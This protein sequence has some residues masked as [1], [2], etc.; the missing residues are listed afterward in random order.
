MTTI[1]NTLN[2]Q[3]FADT[4]YL[5]GIEPGTADGYTGNSLS[6]ENKTHYD[7][8]LIRA[9]QPNLIHAQFAQKRPIP[10]NS[11][12]N[13]EFRKFNPLTKATT[14]ITEGITP[15]GN[16]LEIT[17]VPAEVDQYGD[18]VTVT[19]MLDLTAIDPVIVEATQVIGN[20]AGMTLDTIVR[21]KMHACGN[22]WFAA[23]GGATGGAVELPK[24]VDE[25]DSISY[26]H[27]LTV[28]LL[29]E[30]AAFLKKNNA[31]KIDGSYIGIVH[32]MAAVDIMKDDAWI[33]VN[34]YSDA[35]KIFEGELGKIAGIRFVESSEAKVEVNAKG[36]K[37]FSTLILGQ[38]AY[39][40]TEIEGGG[41][42]VIVK[43]VGSGNDPLNQRATIGWKATKA[44][45]ILLDSNIVK[46]YS[47]TKFGQKAEVN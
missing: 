7:K 29:K 45:E 15:K 9:A 34:S 6:A 38:N 23:E 11:G 8:T 22:V 40:D 13:V 37:Y 39:G 16:K 26:D 19:D 33:D 3:L 20:Q 30:V 32:P 28:G 24:E 35:S 46:V 44:A 43:P 17:T 14:P 2:L 18:Y 1:T 25:W 31:P 41:L 36:M 21:D 10:K 4:N 47:F 42:E 5:N 12:K 27:P